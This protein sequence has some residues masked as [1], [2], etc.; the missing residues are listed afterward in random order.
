MKKL[1]LSL[2]AAA[3]LMTSTAFAPASKNFEGIVTYDVRMESPSLP[4]EA[5]AMM[6]GSQMKMF[7]KNEKAR[8][9][10][11]MGPTENITIVDNKTK[12]AISL[13][14]VMG[15]KY[16]LKS[17]TETNAEAATEIKYV[18]GTK[19][20]AGYKCKKAQMTVT[21]TD[22]SKHNFDVYYT[23]DIPYTGGFKNSIKG[24]KGF[25]ME[26][27]MYAA[28]YNMTMFF[29]A[30]SIA[31]ESVSN[32]KFEVPEGYKETTREQMMKEL[33]GGQ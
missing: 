24:L 26:Y 15:N 12:T 5:I 19:E 9:E 17:N 18:D 2:N 29:T 22:G 13:L 11:K 33:Q 1:L 16:M 20:I 27:G 8:V 31:K 23:E 21:A 28:E 30:K 14:N 3:A 10:L 32:S 4:P 25:P 6:Q 7:I